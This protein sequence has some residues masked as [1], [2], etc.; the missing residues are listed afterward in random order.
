MCENGPFWPPPKQLSTASIVPAFGVHG[1]RARMI[2]D[3]VWSSWMSQRS[4][5]EPGTPPAPAS[6]SNAN[7]SASA[8][9]SFG[10]V[11]LLPGKMP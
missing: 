8:R 7:R 6:L 10:R 9:Q 4:Q 2:R 1:V 3:V 11:T 5:A